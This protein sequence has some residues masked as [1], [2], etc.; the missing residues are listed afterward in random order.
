MLHTVAFGSLPF[1]PLAPPLGRAHLA[2]AKTAACAAGS[3]SAPANMRVLR[4][5]F[6]ATVAM[7]LPLVASL[8]ARGADCLNAQLM[9]GRIAKVM[10]VLVTAL[11]DRVSV[12]TVEAQNAV[13][14]WQ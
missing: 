2:F 9:L 11:A 12:S 4:S 14:I 10:V 13:G 3:R 6:V 8:V 7:H 1:S 5:E